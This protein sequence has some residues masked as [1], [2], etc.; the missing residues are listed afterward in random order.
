LLFKLNGRRLSFSERGEITMSLQNP[1][2]IPGPTNM[3]LAIRHAIDLPTIDHRG[4][5][6]GDMLVPA[7][8]GVRQVLKSSSAEIFIFPATGTGGWETGYYKHPERRG[9]SLSLSQWHVLT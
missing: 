9:Q 7:R 4:P 8:D 2:F 5:G 3:P 1:V 6:F